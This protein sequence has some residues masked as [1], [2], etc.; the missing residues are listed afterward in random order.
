MMH[1]VPVDRGNWRTRLSVRED[2]K[3]YV[4]QPAVIMARAWAYR[5]QRSQVMYVCDGE[6]IVGMIMW[7]DWPEG[8]AYILSE[9]IIDQRYQRKGY[10]RWAVEQLLNMLRADGRYKRVVLCYVDGDEAARS[11]YEK[12]GFVRT[13]DDDEDELGMALEL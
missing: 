9:L 5:E 10:G 3:R 7:H 2:Q 13:W 11:L 1:F 8:E 4:A 12:Y 6:E